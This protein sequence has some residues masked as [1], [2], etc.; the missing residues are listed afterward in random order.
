MSADRRLHTE[1][2]I[3]DPIPLAVAQALIAGRPVPSLRAGPGWPGADTF[4]GLRLDAALGDEERTGWFILLRSTGEV[5][6]DC[7]WRGGPDFRGEAEIGY[8]LAAPY[9]GRRYGSEA[10]AA[11][12]A[13]CRGQPGVRRLSARVLPDNTPS[14]R[15]LAGL[16]FR[17]DGADGE[18]L[19]YVLG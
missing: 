16:G 9:R 5:I 17:P 1:R 19:R 18:H 10:V 3:L 4:G 2:L 13:W 11:L 14:R 15:L 12:V 6:G 7:G 8:G